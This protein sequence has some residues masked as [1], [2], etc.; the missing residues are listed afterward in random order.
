MKASLKDFNRVVWQINGVYHDMCAALGISDSE[1]DVLYVLAEEGGECKQSLI[2]KSTG[3]KKTTINSAIKKLEKN[4]CLRLAA[5]EGRNTRVFLTEAG[6]KLSADTVDRVIA[7]E[8]EMFDSWST[9]DREAM[10]RLNRNYL[11]GLERGAKTL[12][13]GE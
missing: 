10:I 2:Y 5:G 8:N 1:F 13:A 6:R 11:K 12:T 7:I 4:G 9:E 3:Q